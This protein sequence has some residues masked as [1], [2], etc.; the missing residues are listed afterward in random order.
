M[1]IHPGFIYQDPKAYFCAFALVTM[2]KY[3][4]VI[5]YLEKDKRKYTFEERGMV[6]HDALHI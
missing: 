4:N 5:S 1:S 3:L 2:L 6:E